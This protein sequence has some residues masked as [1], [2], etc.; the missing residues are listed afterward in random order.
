MLLLVY[1]SI[2]AFKTVLSGDFGGGVRTRSVSTGLYTLWNHD[3]GA[4]GNSIGTL[5][6][7]TGNAA[8]SKAA[9]YAA[10][11]GDS[12]CAGVTCEGTAAAI[13]NCKKI[14]GASTAGSAARSLT[15][16]VPLKMT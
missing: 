1:C 13:T 6:P 4:A 9:A 11:D 7:L 10:C 14:L 3:A 8:S 5:V 12:E 16:A 2:T 15:R